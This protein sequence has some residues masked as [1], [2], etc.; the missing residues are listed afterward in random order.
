MYWLNYIW[1]VLKVI[2]L[3]NGNGTGW[4]TN[5][6]NESII[7]RTITTIMELVNIQTDRADAIGIVVL[8]H[9]IWTQQ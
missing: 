8:T 2:K 7:D 3:D 6:T 9:K 1:N 5:P 4:K